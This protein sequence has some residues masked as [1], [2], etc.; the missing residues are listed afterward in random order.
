MPCQ[1]SKDSLCLTT[2]QPLSLIP[3][4]FL[5]QPGNEVVGCVARSNNSFAIHEGKKCIHFRIEGLGCL[6]DLSS[7]VEVG[8]VDQ[9]NDGWGIRC[10]RVLQVYLIATGESVGDL[11]RED[12]RVAIVPICTNILQ[13]HTV[14]SF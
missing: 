6:S 2:Q 7:K 13:G 1:D 12:A 4:P 3:R 9:V 5:S 14:L 11:C 10:G 8:M